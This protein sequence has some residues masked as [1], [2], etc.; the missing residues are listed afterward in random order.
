MAKKRGTLQF[1]QTGTG[2]VVTA[3]NGGFANGRGTL[4]ARETNPIPFTATQTTRQPTSTISYSGSEKV[5]E[6][7]K[8]YE[9][10]QK[11]NEVQKQYDGI[12]AQYR[13]KFVR[14]RV[15]DVD[16]AV[17]NAM[18]SDAKAQELKK[19]MDEWGD[20]DF[21]AAAVSNAQQELA[22]SER[23]KKWEDLYNDAVTASDFDTYAQKGGSLENRDYN[24]TRGVKFFGQDT[25]GEVLN[26]VTFTRD[27]ADRIGEQDGVWAS[28]R[29]S[30][31][32]G[33]TSGDDAA[34][35]YYLAMTD[36]EVNIYN[37]YLAKD[38][39]AKA[40][41]FLDSIQ[42][43]LAN[44]VAKKTYEDRLQDNTAMELAFSIA[45]GTDQFASGMRGLSA[46]IGGKD[47]MP[48][49][50]VQQISGSVRENLADDGFGING[51]SIAQVVYDLG[52]TT[53]NMI[54]SIAVASTLSAVNPAL[55]ANVGAALMGSGAAGNAYQEMVNEGYDVNQ[56]RAYATLTGIS[57]ALL[58]RAI[59][60]IAGISGMTPKIA[61]AVAGINKGYMRFAAEFGLEMLSEAT[62][63]GLQEVIDPLLKNAIFGEDNSVNLG[64][65]AYSALLGALSAG[66][67]NGTTSAVRYGAKT[68][69][70]YN[71]LRNDPKGLIESGLESA[72]G[73][74]SRMLAES[75]QAKVDNGGKLTYGE[76]KEL[77]NANITAI[78]EEYRNDAE[79]KLVD[80]GAENAKELAAIIVKERTGNRLS[81]KE[82]DM[83]DSSPA[84]TS[85]L[86]QA[87]AYALELAT[88]DGGTTTTPEVESGEVGATSELD[89]N[90]EESAFTDKAKES[91]MSSAFAMEV[92]G[93]VKGVQKN[94][95][96]A[97]EAYRNGTYGVPFNEISKN[98][99]AAG[100]TNQQRAYIYNKGVADAKLKLFRQ[101]NASTASIGVKKGKVIL[102]T[103]TAIDRTKLSPVQR[104]GLE[105]A[106]VLAGF[107]GGNVHV[108]EST[109]KNGKY[110]LTKDMGG[111]KAG[112][113][114]PN[115]WYDPKTGDIYVD[116]NAGQNGEGVILFTLGHEYTHLIRKKS[117]AKFKK[118][119]DFLFSQYGKKGVSVS[120]L[121][122]NQI[123]KAKNAG[124]S[125]GYDEAYEEVVADSMEQMLLDK[126]FAAKMR[127][128]KKTDKYLWDRLKSL[129]KKMLDAL[130]S[131]RDAYKDYEPNSLE[132]RL[133]S[134]FSEDARKKLAEMYAEAFVD[135]AANNNAEVADTASGNDVVTNVIDGQSILN[136]DRFVEPHYELIK[137]K[138]DAKNAEVSVDALLERYKKAVDIWRELG[139]ELDSKF[140]NDWNNQ[141]YKNRAFTVFKAQQG[142][143]YNAELS[144][145]CKKG[146][147]LFEAI[148]TIVKKEVM[149][150]LNTKTIGK[151][152]KEILYDI[153]KAH[154]FEIPCAI[155]YVEQARQREGVI[156]DAFLNGK[157]EYDKQGNKTKT[158]LG[159]NEVLDRVEQKMH[160]MG[161]DYTIPTVDRSI[162]T[163]KYTPAPADMDEA[164]QKAFYDALREVTN[165]E[166]ERYNAED[167]PKNPKRL[168]KDSTPAEVNAV[169][170]GTL[171]SNLRIFKALFQNPDSRFRLD[172][173]LLYSSMTTK[174]IATAHHALYTIFNSQG[175]VSGYKT[176]QGAVVY[177]GDFLKKKWTSPATRK[178]GG[179][180][181]Q[182]NSDFMMYML[183]DYVQMYVDLTAKGYYLQAYTKV[184][185][186]LKLFGLSGA[187]INASFI[188][189]VVVYTN[190]DGSVDIER[191]RENAGL[192]ES[193]NPIYDDIEGIDH[194]EAFMII[195]DGDYSK[196]I[197][198]VCIGYSDKHIIKVLDDNRI[199][200]I[201]GY[202]DKTDDPDKRYRGARYAKNYNGLNEAT[203]RKSDGTTET[204]H[205]G[206][207][208]FVIKAEGYFKKGKD[209]SF[210]GTAQVNGKTYGVDDIPNLAADLYL[211]HC[212]EKGYSPAY[213]IPGMVDHTNYY[214]L[215]ADFAL[216]DKDGHYAPHRKVNFKLP[217]SVPYLDVDGTK[218]YMS[219]KAYI[220]AELTKEMATRDAI[221]E[222]L[223][224]NSKDGIIPQFIEQVNN[225][226]APSESRTMMS[227]R[228]PEGVSDFQKRN[229]LYNRAETSVGN[230]LKT[231]AG[232]TI[233][234]YGWTQKNP[235]GVGKQLSYSNKKRGESGS[236]V[237]L[238]KEY[239]YDVVPKAIYD[240]AVTML[241]DKYPDFEWNTIMYLHTNERDVVRFDE[242]PDF[243]TAREP[244]PGDQI[245][246]NVTDGSVSDI[247]NS[248][249]IWHHKWLWVKN[250]YDGFDVSE[251]WN[252]SKL[253]LSVIRDTKN[254]NELIDGTAVRVDNRGI[255]N[256]MGKGV[257]WWNK[258]LSYFGLPL[259]GED[260]D[261]DVQTPADRYVANSAAPSES[262][263]MMSLRD[264]DPVQPSNNSWSRTKTTAEAMEVFP[265]MWNVAADESESRNPTQ[266]KSTVGTYRKIYDIL[267]NEGFNGT[268]LDASSGLGVGTET[269]RKEYGFAVED[270]E[271]F[272]SS[273]YHPM[274]TDYSALDKKYD[275]IIS[276]AVLNVLPQDQRDALVVKMGELL[277][278]GGRMFIT[279]RGKDVENLSNTGKNIHLGDMEWIET[280]KGSYQ[281]GFTNPELIA[282]LRDALGD[283]FTVVGA[284]KETGGKFN[285]NTNVVVTKDGGGIA[286]SDREAQNIPFSDY[287][288]MERHFGTTKNYDVAGY[289][290]ID[291]ELLDFSGK[292]WGDRYSTF[293]QVDHRDIQEVI[294]DRGNNGINA[295]VDMIANRNIRLMPEIGG[296]NLAYAP[297]GMQANELR[298]Y[299]NHFRGEVIVDIDS[300]GGDTILSFT[301]NKGTSSTKV[302]NDISDYFNKGIIPD[303]ANRSAN[304]LDL[305]QFLY[306]E[307]NSESY[308]SRSI[309]SAAST[310]VAQNATE[311]DYLE[312]YFTTSKSLAYQEQKLSDVRD[313]IRKTEDP[314]E[315]RKLQREG[316]NI[317]KVIEKRH[318]RL[319]ELEK[320][321]PL[322]DVVK[323]ERAKAIAEAEQ[324]GRDALAAYKERS[325]RKY[326]ETV[327]RYRDSRKEGVENR[328]KKA[329][330]DSIN[331]T[332]NDFRQ[333]ILHPTDT[334]YAPIGLIQACF[335]LATML[336]TS[337]AKEDTKAKAKYRSMMEALAVLRSQYDALQDSNDSDYATEYDSDFSY[338]VSQLSNRIGGKPVRDLTLAELQDVHDILHDIKSMLQDARYQLGKADKVTNYSVGESIIRDAQ[339]AM[340]RNAVEQKFDSMFRFT[341]STLRN[342]R[343]IV[344]YNENAALMKLFNDLD[345]GIRKKNR[346]VMESDK[347]F[348]AY[349]GNRF[350]SAATDV[351][352]YNT[353]KRTIRMTEMEAIQLVL[354]WERELRGKTNHLMASGIVIPNHEMLRKGKVQDAYLNGEE[355]ANIEQDEILAIQD[356]FDEWAN[357]YKAAAKKFFNGKAKTAI[358]DTTMAL[359]HRPVALSED[360]IPIEV[361]RNTIVAEL[362][363][364]KFDATIEG[365]G[366]L[367]SVVE[368]ASNP[369]II[370]G[371]HNVVEDHI[372]RVGQ[373]YGLAIPIRNFNKA[374]NVKL[375]GTDITP[376]KAIK[377]AADIDIIEKAVSDLQT[378]RPRDNGPVSKF[379]R[380]AQGRF[381]EATLLS[382]ISVTIKQAASY[383]T[384]GLYL[385]Q[386]ALAPY[387]K[388]IAQ[389]FANNESDFAKS[390]FAEIDAHTATHYMRRKGMSMQEIS[391]IAQDKSKVVRWMDDK[392]PDVA[393]PLKWIQN[394][395]VATT[396]AL[397]LA[398][399][400]QVE[401]NGMK[402]D[403]A[404]YWDAVTSL[405]EKVIGDTQPMYDVL[406]RPEMQKNTNELL[407]SV[408]MF[409]TQPL[410][411]SG[412]LY[413]ALGNLQAAQKSGNANAIK[414]AKSRMAH[415]VGSQVA[416]LAVFAT[417][418]FVAYAIRNRL[419]RY[420][421]DEG[422]VTIESVTKRVLDD[423]AGNALQLA[424]P[425]GGDWLNTFIENKKSGS[426]FT[427][428]II[429]VPLVDRVTDYATDFG[430]VWSD[431][432]DIGN[433]GIEK[434]MADIGTMSMDIAGMFGIPANNVYN[435]FRGIVGNISDMTGHPIDWATDESSST[436]KLAIKSFENG[437]FDKGKSRVKELI[438]DKM[439]N[440]KTEKEA[441]SAIRSSFTSYWKPLYK[442]AYAAKNDAELARIRKILSA[443]GLY[444][445]ASDIAETC[446][447]WLKN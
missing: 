281:K 92:Y 100:L 345:D 205:I 143:K 195:E 273:D 318:N 183:L 439:S 44:R 407:N 140:L 81:N 241:K 425:V 323:R 157:V 225:L 413:D 26:K 74:K 347:L 284:S 294:D 359:K 338:M 145:M 10:L 353:G 107:V 257:D 291:G 307:R 394:M 168:L 368:G 112:D 104:K 141:E 161:V 33:N 1:T 233:K 308:D 403:D 288:R 30:L 330:R 266:I 24:A 207:N 426:F 229:I 152:E 239:A 250:D 60:G 128:L 339:N 159:W 123:T 222:A 133:V 113:A 192:D 317:R 170:K 363:G 418:S 129:F 204:V 440:G 271:P 61:K 378:P 122:E 91:G 2:N 28:I 189:R 48:Y 210:S 85:V 267:K 358:N 186:E 401:L 422:E 377:S 408:F 63:E 411:N 443:S 171:P 59:G 354:T 34:N 244:I 379:L 193:G 412:I 311:K 310:D 78:Y 432:A 427:N 12:A 50:E 35:A 441:K 293:R 177:L 119:A 234:R 42:E 136:H 374:F 147:P 286:Y 25:P 252:W 46:M 38:G 400:K 124:R 356:T 77:R 209:G 279:T 130:T 370:R 202:H 54:P 300:V 360:Y 349:L 9:D 213:N 57:E 389:L 376:R 196:S 175:G 283:G 178:E 299:I 231:V 381:V 325:E 259:D 335:D 151:A 45:A 372:N 135:A 98:G 409:K 16:K 228:D 423:M 282:Y 249:Q 268:I 380:Q 417:M 322:R 49:S 158:K 99:F 226:N 64:D 167:K 383:S 429:S 8:R 240:S 277:K 108:Y 96:G 253:W 5:D 165:E 238:H 23:L 75:A 398:T 29:R 297:N 163:E 397:W 355:Y 103:A 437:H 18:R 254:T 287:E 139:G 72:D 184:P 95:L 68:L 235:D 150:Q 369:V 350:A 188:P 386:K 200:Q 275:V 395:D 435:I 436:A 67:M 7:R 198:G 371:L 319:V 146:I 357:G 344:G 110:V 160:D 156:I 265:N 405:Y 255:A 298:G 43:S 328:K 258:Q 270:I 406:H 73:T 55:G 278:D 137:A 173:D 3:G 191:T 390:L 216:K 306:S 62:E 246:V 415:A 302:M 247:V 276:S 27:N 332:A 261:Y 367:K 348:E 324:R 334:R 87:A 326:A 17:E 66:V 117:R 414:A 53:A 52:S 314:K 131:A 260:A 223:A 272:P 215:L 232:T 373:L 6:N 433:V 37:Y 393:N 243:D 366:M 138:F 375:I 274:Y 333:M 346:F 14:Q 88:A 114:A 82:R 327:Q 93:M 144:S 187:K 402:P 331:K 201:I 153:L 362:E 115:G 89:G 125:I 388:T 36:D 245:S 352:E 194:N 361:D 290:L 132:A 126:N 56:A 421:D 190:A 47:Y 384:A 164:T 285:N 71:G 22:K 442:A 289:L 301:Y 445:N 206:F 262:R 174:N 182:S 97:I 336:D 176:K 169:L 90:A 430:K 142:Y 127:E 420:K 20:I 416:S 86:E 431:V 391:T 118:L 219:T 236:Q 280:V 428:D 227:L 399:K 248:Q 424:L 102:E 221:S 337:G 166:I 313:A 434:T 341:G 321:K 382:N 154:N 447:N 185:A 155:C 329:L 220:K 180:R 19:Q 396:A 31:S 101:Q 217:E 15:V 134:E 199:Q 237:Y 39:E 41:E 106:E 309:L 410:Q 218:K 351:K 312:S 263:T 120:T 224:D 387:Q 40:Q 343:R 292:H 320:S 256:G 84:A 303:S 404:G 111:R 51:N 70:D 121:I 296:I 364:V 109:R 58:E 4:S 212:E 13:A 208:Q 181:N 230:P 11:K 295:M 76:I 105:T 21:S 32:G 79:Q 203:K 148:D 444:G 69:N 211:A 269:G 251:S 305:K 419:G 197:G 94:Q 264:V 446:R 162:A 342:I 438:E 149:N 214:K 172:N 316:E 83:L 65:V 80:M 242:A 116:L 365:M 179:I 315:I 385:S 340:P 304:N 392:L